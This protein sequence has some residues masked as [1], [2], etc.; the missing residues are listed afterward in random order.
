[1]I[2]ERI[3]NMNP[4]TLIITVILILLAF[5]IIAGRLLSDL[6]LG[7]KRQT[8]EE[9]REWQEERID[10]GWYDIIDKQTYKVQSFDGYTLNVQLLI[11]P[12]PSEKYVII[13][14]GYTD[15]LIGSL[16]YAKIY[17]DLGFNVV[18][19]DL[20]GHGLN[21]PTY[22]TYT[23]RE[24]KDLRELIKDTISRHQDMEALGLHG[25]SLGAATSIAVLNY[26]PDIDFIVSDCAFSDIKSVLEGGLRSAHLPVSILKLAGFFI[27]LRFQVSFNGMRP[28]DCLKGNRKP[29]LFIHGQDDDLIPPYHSE[30]M[31]AETEGYKDLR[32][33]KG[34]G[35]AES[36]LKEPEEYAE[37]VREF[38]D[39]VYNDK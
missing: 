32:L 38:L 21:E 12:V 18:I 20:R 11:N 22:C 4:A 36:V 30:M 9:A 39:V 19:Y 10:I 3:G 27:K 29:I 5:L 17:I 37:Y 28:I 15:N 25:E 8:Y 2:P 13:S 6:L 35:H 1:L 14:H 31:V 23:V 7:I 24:R 33:I 16:K 26:Q 34:A